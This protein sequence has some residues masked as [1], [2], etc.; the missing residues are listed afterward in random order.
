MFEQASELPDLDLAPPDLG[1]ELA[2]SILLVLDRRL[3]N[4]FAAEVRGVTLARAKQ[5]LGS[6][7]P[8]QRSDGA[9][10]TMFANGPTWQAFGIDAEADATAGS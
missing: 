7:D 2:K 10:L 4:D 1:L 9:W 8:E 6:A 3:D 5:W